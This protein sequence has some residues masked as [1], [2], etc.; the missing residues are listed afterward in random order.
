MG[1][2]PTTDRSAC[3]PL[4]LKSRMLTMNITTPIYFIIDIIIAFIYL[5]Y[6]LKRKNRAYLKVNKIDSFPIKLNTSLIRILK[7]QF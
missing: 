7:N 4:D 1:I 2:E 5:F 3:L 6:N